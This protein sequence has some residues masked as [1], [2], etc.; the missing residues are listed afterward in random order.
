MGK[1]SKV[2]FRK[3]AAFWHLPR[4]EKCWF[5]PV[6]AL[7]GLGRLMVLCVAFR[8]IAPRLGAHAGLTPWTPLLNAKNEQRAR[9][10][11]R[12]IEIAARYTPWTSNCFPQAIA[13]R[14]LLGLYGI[15]YVL[16]FGLHQDQGELKAHAWVV[17]GKVRVSGGNSFGTFTVV[18]C[19]IA[20]ALTSLRPYF[21]DSMTKTA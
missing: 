20:P 12:I 17:A 10:I 6:L 14:I 5:I 1:R 16:F 9:H 13:A 21:A 3:F 8:Q 18:G 4:F 11:R 19:F 15:P 2:V 7:L